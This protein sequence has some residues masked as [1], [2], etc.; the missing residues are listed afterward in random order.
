LLGQPNST[1]FTYHQCTICAMVADQFALFVPLCR[2]PHN[3]HILLAVY[4]YILVGDLSALFWSVAPLPTYL[5]TKTTNRHGLTV[6]APSYQSLRHSQLQPLLSPSRAT[7]FTPFVVSSCFYEVNLLF[8]YG[9]MSF[10][11]IFYLRSLKA[12]REVIFPPSPSPFFFFFFS[13][14]Y[15][16][17]Y[18][19]LLN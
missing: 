2:R 4:H 11:I 6:A 12:S 14:F 19:H 15:R 1:T 17:C 16:H 7:Y 9:K 5:P 8:V 13:L 3:R 10:Y 18:G